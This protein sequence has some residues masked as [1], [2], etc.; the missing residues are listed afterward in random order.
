MLSILTL[1]GLKGLLRFGFL[2]ELFFE[3]GLFECWLLGGIISSFIEVFC[4]FM[5]GPCWLALLFRSLRLA[6]LNLWGSIYVVDVAF[7]HL[8]S[9]ERLW[10]LVDVLFAAPLVT[11]AVY[12]LKGSIQSGLMWLEPSLR[13]GLVPNKMS[14]ID[15]NSILVWELAAILRALIVE[16]MAILVDQMSLFCY[17]LLQM[18]EINC[19]ALRR[20]LPV[21]S[22]SKD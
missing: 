4:T 8:D 21:I 12:L 19:F 5:K 1:R 2:V 18:D 15:I 7:E 22:N 20:S 14:K 10:N 9:F 13:E 11:V 16:A 3:I 6:D 17:S